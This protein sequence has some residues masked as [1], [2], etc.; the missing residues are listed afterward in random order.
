MLTSPGIILTNLKNEYT[1]M[2]DNLYQEQNS[3]SCQ[4]IC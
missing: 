4:P 3:I 2:Y 1:H